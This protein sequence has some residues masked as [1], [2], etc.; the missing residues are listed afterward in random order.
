[1]GIIHFDVPRVRDFLMR[2]G[3]VYTLRSRRRST[4]RALAVSN[5]E[6]IG[7]V[8]VVFI[9]VVNVNNPHVLGRYVAWSGFVSVDEWVRT[10]HS[11]NKHAGGTAY[12]YRVEL[13]RPLAV[14]S[15]LSPRSRRA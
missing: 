3:V 7:V 15:S 11:V 1:M 9:G 8:N 6:P 12:L 10:Y 14:G 13:I 5:G 4:G 2:Y